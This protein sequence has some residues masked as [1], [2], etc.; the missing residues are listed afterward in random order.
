MNR[1]KRATGIEFTAHSLR[2]LYATTLY[3]DVGADLIT[4]KGLMRHSKAET[5]ITRYIAP[6]KKLENEAA[7][8]LENVLVE[9]LGGF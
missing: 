8:T 3:Y 4:I 2:R 1:L 9:A 6:M 5:T 7:K